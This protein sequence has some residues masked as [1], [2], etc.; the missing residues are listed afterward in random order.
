MHTLRLPAHLLNSGTW[1]AQ[2]SDLTAPP[3][4]LILEARV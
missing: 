3:V 1:A 4:I 2:Q